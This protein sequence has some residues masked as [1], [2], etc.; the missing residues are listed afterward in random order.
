MAKTPNMR[1]SA[2]AE[3]EAESVREVL[4]NTS[5]ALKIHADEVRHA[6][7]IDF[8]SIELSVIVGS[9]VSL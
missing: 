5:S 9:R 8:I 6:P 7:N 1:G 3:T 2:A 4:K